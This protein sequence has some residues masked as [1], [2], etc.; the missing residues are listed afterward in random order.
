MDRV[1][2]QAEEFFGEAIVELE[3]INT[4]HNFT[5]HETHFGRDVW[6]SRKGAISAKLGEAGLI[7][8]SMG[9]ASYVVVGRG[10]K[11]ALE[12]SPHGAGRR[13]SRT[14]ARRTFTHEQLREAMAGIEFRDTEAFL[15]EIPAAYKDIDVV[16]ADASDLVEV[17]HTLRQILNVKG[18]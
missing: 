4:H 1:V 5:E 9:T 18:D 6:L 10:N 17:R 14:T 16:M 8:G 2:R 11:L 3:R 15:D 13:F 12:S 7:P